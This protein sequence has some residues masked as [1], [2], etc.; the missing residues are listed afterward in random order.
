MVTVPPPLRLAVAVWAVALVAGRAAAQTTPT[1]RTA[2]GDVLRQIEALQGRLAPGE[3]G[4]APG[5][6]GRPRPD[7]VLARRGSSGTA[8]CRT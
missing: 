4:R 2:A 1:E 5:R 6:P 7:R 3:A 8:G